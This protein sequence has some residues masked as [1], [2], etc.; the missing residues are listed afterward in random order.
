MVYG[1]F[2]NRDLESYQPLVSYFI[3]WADREELFYF[4]VQ[5]VSDQDKKY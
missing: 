3:Y 5:P 1:I 2:Y 4:K